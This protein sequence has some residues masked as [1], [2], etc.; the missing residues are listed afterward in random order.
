MNK[1]NSVVHVPKPNSFWREGLLLYGGVCIYACLAGVFRAQ[2]WFLPGLQGILAAG[3]L[4]AWHGKRVRGNTLVAWRGGQRFWYWLNAGAAFTLITSAV[5]A[6]MASPAGMSGWK[7]MS[8]L[9]SGLESEP[10]FGISVFNPTSPM[11]GYLSGGGWIFFTWLDHLLFLGIGLIFFGAFAEP[12]QLRT[13]EAPPPGPLPR[14]ART[15]FLIQTPLLLVLLVSG[16]HLANRYRPPRAPGSL[17]EQIAAREAFLIHEGLYVF[18]DGATLLAPAGSPVTLSL[19]L[20][21]W[22]RLV[23]HFPDTPAQELWIDLHEAG[24]RARL[25]RNQRAYPLQ[26]TFQENSTLLEISGQTA[27]RGFVRILSRPKAPLPDERPLPGG[28]EGLP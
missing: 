10:F 7:W 16:F 19:R 13:T 6:I 1:T 26:A 17:S 25:I 24:A 3:I 18:D 14:Q 21:G 12:G 4:G 8:R 9:W 11:S 20:V 23:G 27:Q 28:A 5:P 15:W 22:N 2:N